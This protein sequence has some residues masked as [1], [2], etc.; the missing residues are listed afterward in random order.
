MDPWVPY[1]VVSIL[2]PIHVKQCV[3]SGLPFHFVPRRPTRVRTF[4]EE[5]TVVKTCALG[6]PP[7]FS[8]HG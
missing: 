6:G 4:G 5:G 3:S 2:R 8:T 7:N 1:D